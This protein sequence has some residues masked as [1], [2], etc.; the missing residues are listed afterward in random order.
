VVAAFL[1]TALL[2]APP[3]HADTPDGGVRSVAFGQVDAHFE[4]EVRGDTSGAVCDVLPRRLCVRGGVVRYDGR[5]VAAT[6]T[7]ARDAFEAR[8][9]ASEI[10][11]AHGT[12]T[13][14][15]EAGTDRVPDSGAFSATRPTLAQGDC[16]AAAAR[17]KRC[18]KP[19]HALVPTLEEAAIMPNAPCRITVPTHC[20]FGVT[21][22]RRTAT[23]VLLGDT[24]AATWRAEL[25]VVAQAKRWRGVS[26]TRP[27][28]PFSTRILGPQAASSQSERLI[29]PQ[30]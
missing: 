19:H 28:C 15:V 8:F 3:V 16:F 2:F 21:G 7:R 14:W 6:V 13:W 1:S 9:G 22:T 20:E 30:S 10:P 24:H 11:L 17:A 27:G 26:I 5:R 25:E 4:L 23:F 29:S 12:F 18:A